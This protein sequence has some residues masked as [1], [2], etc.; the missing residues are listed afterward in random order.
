MT[1]AIS[2][3]LPL[4]AYRGPTVAMLR[5]YYD[6]SL[7]FGRVPSVLGRELFRANITNVHDAWFEDSVNFVCDVEHCVETL[8]PGHREV[9]KRLIFQGYTQ[10]ELAGML[11]LTDR[12]VRRLLLDALDA[13]SQIFL[14]RDLMVL[15]QRRRHMMSYDVLLEDP[16]YEEVTPTVSLVDAIATADSPQTIYISACA[17]FR[18]HVSLRNIPAWQEMPVENSCQAPLLSQIAANL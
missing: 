13:L 10:E 18:G 3:P 16:E 5:R 1:S 11:H 9:I 8:A 14:D 7:Q 2:P 17:E 6:M 12:H 4:R 15:P